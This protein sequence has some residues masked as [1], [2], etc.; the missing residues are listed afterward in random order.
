MD[1]FIKKEEEPRKYLIAT[2]CATKKR[3]CIQFGKNA[4]K[5]NRKISKL[6]I[7]IELKYCYTK[8]TEQP[9]AQCCKTNAIIK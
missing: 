2:D 1:Y 7:D 6:Y 5:S 9:I 3:I 8:I 4:K